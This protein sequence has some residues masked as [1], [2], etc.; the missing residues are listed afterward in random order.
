M[1]E[2]QNVI[3]KYKTPLIIGGVLIVGY[4]AYRLLRK[5]QITTKQTIAKD[6]KFF[7]KQGQSLSYTLTS[8]VGFADSIYNAWFQNTNIFNSVDETKIFAV[9]GKMKNDLD[10]LQLIKSFGRRR[11]PVLFISLLTPNLTLPEWLNEALDTKEIDNVN[12][13]LAKN[14]IVYRF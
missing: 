13:I 12:T 3:K 5:K 11:S 1:Q 10:V 14:N 7:V 8:Y 2:S 9:I 4:I 6:E